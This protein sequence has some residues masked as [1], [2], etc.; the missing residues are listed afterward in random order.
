M[1][2]RAARRT[3]RYTRVAL[4]RISAAMKSQLAPGPRRNRPAIGDGNGPMRSRARDRA[5][6]NYNRK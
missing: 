1:I 6:L 2:K 3:D 5:D 4:S